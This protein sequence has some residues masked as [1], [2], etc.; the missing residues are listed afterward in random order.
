[1]W[2][3]ACRWLAKVG[4]ASLLT[5]CGSDPPNDACE[6]RLGRSSE[7]PA[8]VKLGAEPQ[9]VAL[10][11]PT[12]EALPGAH[13][14][15]G[16]LGGT[17]YQ[18]ELPDRWNGGLVMWMHGFENFASEAQATPPDFRRYLIGHGFAWAASSFSSTSMVPSLAADETAALWDHFA[19][20]HG[21]PSRSYAAGLS[22]GGWAAHLSAERYPD[23]YDGALGLCGAVGTSPALRISIEVLVAAAFAAKV[24]PAEFDA[25][26]SVQKLLDERIRPALQDPEVHAIF[27]DVGIA[28]SGGPRRFAREGFHL[29]EETN[30]TRAALAILTGLVPERDEPYELSAVPGVTSEEFAAQAVQPKAN[31]SLLETFAQGME[32]SG[33]LRM[34]LVTLHTTGDGQVPLD[35]ARILNA[36]ASS[37][38]KASLLATRVIEDSGHCGFTTS[39]QALAFAALVSWA[40]CG[41]KP[42]ATPLAKHDL[43]NLDPT[44]ALL[45][46][47][48]S[49]AEQQVPGFDARLA[50]G[51]TLSVDGEAFDA[52]FLGAT[53][54]RN[55]LAA[56]CQVGLVPVRQG[57]YQLEVLADAESAGCGAPDSELLLWTHTQGQFL[58]TTTSFAWPATGASAAFDAS[59]S[60]AKPQG[61]APVFRELRGEAFHED[62][63]TVAPGTRIEAR[64]GDVVCGVASTRRTGSYEGFVL[65][66]VGPDSVPGCELGAPLSFW[67]GN[68]RARETGVNDSSQP[69]VLDL[70]IP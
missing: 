58:R 3:R 35:Q 42:R 63:N 13:A 68:A 24:T 6:P 56:A 38:G 18:I 62:G 67:V 8:A 34:P 55:G 20:V 15:F 25:A 70:T 14:E 21:R 9:G 7:L 11:D 32:V 60:S 10:A 50:L 39:E 22:M 26:A 65:H 40:E 64:I 5:G 41:K 29:E 48:G 44:F 31:P 51:G 49:D 1:M 4:G 19:K 46:R 66:V 52:A 30:L 43:E 54:L 57:K 28:L 45:P 69:E 36:R 33:E 47:A 12:F 2:T 37:R 17:A 59:F 53:V 23:R 61:V 16:R 27:E